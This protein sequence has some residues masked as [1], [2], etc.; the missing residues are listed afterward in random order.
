[1]L[2]HHP[3]LKR[4]WTKAPKINK[5]CFTTLN[6]RYKATKEFEKEFLDIAMKSMSKSVQGNEKKISGLIDFALK[7]EK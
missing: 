1:M 4:L 5:G 7:D 2:K 6:R 3:K